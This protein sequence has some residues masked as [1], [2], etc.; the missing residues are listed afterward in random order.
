MDE[1][2]DDLQSLLSYKD[3][4]SSLS[5]E[6]KNCF[7]PENLSGVLKSTV[8][9]IDSI[10]E[11]HLSLKFPLKNDYQSE[12]NPNDFPNL[13]EAQYQEQQD[14]LANSALAHNMDMEYL[15]S[16]DEKEEPKFE[17]I[18]EEKIAI[19]EQKI[20][21][22]KQTQD[23]FE[24]GHEGGKKERELLSR[25]TNRKKDNKKKLSKNKNNNNINHEY[26]FINNYTPVYYPKNIQLQEQN[27]NDL[28]KHIDIQKKKQQKDNLFEP[29]NRNIKKKY[30][31]N[32]EEKKEYESK[33]K[34]LENKL[35]ELKKNFL[36]N[37][38]NKGSPPQR[39]DKKEKIIHSRKNN[40]IFNKKYIISKLEISSPLKDLITKSYFDVPKNLIDEKN[41]KDEKYIIDNLNYINS[42]IFEYLVNT[43][44][45]LKELKHEKDKAK[46]KKASKKCANEFDEFDV[47]VKTV[48][49]MDKNLIEELEKHIT[50]L[51]FILSKIGIKD[52]ESFTIS[53]YLKKLLKKFITTDNK[54][55]LSK[56]QLK[57]IYRIIDAYISPKKVKKELKMIKRKINNI[58]QETNKNSILYNDDELLDKNLNNEGSN[59]LCS[60]ENEF[61]N[62][63]KEN[64]KIFPKNI[65]KMH[66]KEN[67]NNIK[68]N[69]KDKSDN[70]T[71][72]I[73]IRN[74]HIVNI[75]KDFIISQF[76]YKFNNINKSYKLIIKANKF[77]NENIEEYNNKEEK[78]PFKLE[79]KFEDFTNQSFYFQQPR[80][81]LSNFNYIT[82]YPY[83]NLNVNSFVEIE[84][85]NYDNEIQKNNGIMEEDNII[86]KNEHEIKA[87]DSKVIIIYIT[88]EN[89]N[90]S[91]I[92]F[93][94][95]NSNFEKVI[96]EAKKK[97]K[98]DGLKESEEAKNLIN[99]IKIDFL[100]EI[101]KNENLIMKLFTKIKNNKENLWK[102]NICRKITEEIFERQDLNGLVI[103]LFYSE[104]VRGKNLH[105]K[106]QDKF[107]DKIRNLGGYDYLIP[108]NNC[109]NNNIKSYM[110]SFIKML[111]NIYD[112]LNKKLVL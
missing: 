94:F 35:N 11:G 81:E 100:F 102:T 49:K 38:Q 103:T 93:D 99:T 16:I 13:A 30:F 107:I 44:K 111:V 2:K 110:E 69:N 26:I 5:E 78:D 59:D 36:K 53:K 88:L 90:N 95:M 18:N 22:K 112:H 105:Y 96:N 40:I 98:Y 77:I 80:I 41:R 104:K 63:R 47:F 73:K 108:N 64:L 31:K 39:K 68:T 10:D 55:T 91:E 72:E 74:D 109:I 101:L 75:I 97:Q 34:E 42:K 58:N 6:L 92:D 12:Q 23:L 28:S 21:K 82:K 8:G 71:K 4:S 9:E 65:E 32:E 20:K 87:N 50:K 85:E 60:F 3:E 89:K 15:A 17:D 24:N 57:Q 106:E 61:L 46:E 7:G 1:N 66:T 79:Y 48:E 45:K 54:K 27:P 84:E 62:N 52:Y 37:A 56:P 43:V 19:N 70:M 33:K 76:V 25:K 67:E 83:L 86:K 14:N 29:Y 51:T